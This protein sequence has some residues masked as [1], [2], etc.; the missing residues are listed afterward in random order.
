MRIRSKASH[1]LACVLIPALAL[2]ACGKKEPLDEPS[3]VTEAATP[4]SGVDAPAESEPRIFTDAL[5]RKVVDYGN[6]GKP[7]TDKLAEPKDLCSQSEQER[8]PEG[9]EI[10]HVG[11]VAT[12]WSTSDGPAEVSEVGTPRKYAHTV[13]GA[14]LAGMNQ[15]AL[16]TARDE[17]AIYSMQHDYYWPPD[18]QE[19]L[20]ELIAGVK[21]RDIPPS[22]VLDV[23]AVAAH[24]VVTC[25]PE[26]MVID[27]AQPRIADD[28]GVRTELY[29]QVFRVPLVWDG[30]WGLNAID[31]NDPWREKF[32]HLDESW[33][34]WSF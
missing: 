11:G 15:G 7:L 9:L 22:K 1:A 18:M 20:D 3:P 32:N 30:D 16:M 31:P 17:E 13:L 12:V 26:Q 23:P 25:S 5:G 10:Q 2:G 4:T 33:V 19:K 28:Q 29:Y 6:G 27:L 14:A 21:D 34:K 24:R 8:A